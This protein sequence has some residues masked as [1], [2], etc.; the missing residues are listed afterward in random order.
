MKIWDRT[1]ISN[2]ITLIL[3]WTLYSCTYHE[4]EPFRIPQ[5]PQPEETEDLEASFTTSSPNSVNSALW[6][7]TDFTL[8]EVVDDVTGEV[9]DEDG[10]LNVSGTH[11]GL[12]G[13]NDGEDPELTLRAAFDETN[14]YILATW[15]D[16]RYD[17]ANR[18]WLY[19]GPSDPLKPGES[20]DGWTSQRSDDNII[21]E[22]DMGSGKKDVWKWSLALSEPMGFAIDMVRDGNNLDFDAGDKMFVRNVGGTGNR[23]G[24]AFEWDA[25]PQELERDPGGFTILDP[26]FF[27]LN[28]TAF[29]GDVVNGE[30]IYQDD[31]AKC[32][33][34]EG[35]GNGFEFDTN[36]PMNVPGGLNRL[37][38]NALS[39]FMGSN[40]HDGAGDFNGLSQ[41]EKQEE[42]SYTNFFSYSAYTIQEIPKRVMY[43]NR[44]D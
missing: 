28:K 7:T 4:N 44:L 35:D 15:K 10:L 43:V 34:V 3:V 24:P 39:D 12:T 26:G 40:E 5:L 31:C 33:G 38:R 29:E 17:V 9:S 42:R 18:T 41:E 19:D 27:L 8:I 13:F 37:S 25:Q 20:A 16:G 22:F 11:A 6:S 30:M 36:I 21:F 32:H 23:A 14:I 2:F 1:V